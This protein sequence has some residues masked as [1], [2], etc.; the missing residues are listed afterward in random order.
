M[1][2]INWTIQAKNDLKNIFEFI[3]KDSANYARIHVM[4]IR[5]LKEVLKTH[6]TIG[7]VV[8]EIDEP[9]IRELIY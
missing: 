7:I 5:K 2:Q 3:A 9:Q 8:D 1:V 4:K 6:P